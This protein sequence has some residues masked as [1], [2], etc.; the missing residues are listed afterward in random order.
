MDGRDFDWFTRMQAWTGNRRGA[1]AGVAALWL[2]RGRSADAAQLGPSTCGASGE[3]CTMLVG[4]CS[5]LTC[6]TSGI[7]TNYGVCVAGEGGTI[8]AGTGLISP[9]SDG[10][11]DEIAARADSSA[12]ATD[13][14]TP[15]ELREERRQRLAD[16]RARER[17]RIADQRL[18]ERE[19]RDR[20]RDRRARR[21]EAEELRRGP[22]LEFAILNPGGAGGRTETLLVTNHDEDPVVLTRIETLIEPDDGTSIGITL[23]SGDAY[24]FYSRNPE[25]DDDIAAELA[26]INIPVCGP[27]PGDGFKLYASFSFETENKEFDVLCRSAEVAAQ[28]RGE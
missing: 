12:T 15:E 28:S 6:V 4:C 10:A 17:A 27:V 11:V 13:T 24:R 1:I 7:N 25:P 16:R 2:A 5:G 21:R 18:R 3:V 9:F 23:S 22:E 14:P 8:A 19:R 20:R 26:W